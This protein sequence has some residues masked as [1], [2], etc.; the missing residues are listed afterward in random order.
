VAV[1]LGLENPRVNPSGN[2][3]KRT[4]K[5]CKAVSFHNV[6]IY[7]TLKQIEREVSHERLD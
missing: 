3:K 1:E 5:F 2:K 6:L 4:R 7:K